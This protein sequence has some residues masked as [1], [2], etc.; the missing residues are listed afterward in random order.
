MSDLRAR[1]RLEYLKEMGIAK[2]KDKHYY[3][4]HEWIDTLK[5][6]GR[7]NTFL[8]ARRYLNRE[9]N[10]RLKLYTEEAGTISG[11]VRYCYKMDDEA[12][13]GN[14][15]VIQGEDGQGWYVPVCN[16]PDT[17]LVNKDISLRLTHSQKGKLEPEITILN[18]HSL[19]VYKNRYQIASDKRTERDF[20]AWQKE[21]EKKKSKG[22]SF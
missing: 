9:E 22:L 10:F 18:E 8:D 3:L 16:P 17:T 19:N 6:L 12:V 7:Y 5:A 13:W 4:E 1:K 14:A 2:Y 20:K 11:C 21:Q 15:Y